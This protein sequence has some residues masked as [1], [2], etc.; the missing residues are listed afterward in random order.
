[1]PH[2]GPS[3]SPVL[4]PA[5][6]TR[7]QQD[8]NLVTRRRRLPLEI[9]CARGQQSPVRRALLPPTLAGQGPLPILCT[10]ESSLCR[11]Q[12]TW[13][14]EDYRA[15]TRGRSPYACI[16]LPLRQE[17]AASRPHTTTQQCRCDDAGG[18][19]I[20]ASQK[21]CGRSLPACLLPSTHTCADIQNSRVRARLP[22]PWPV[23]ARCCPQSGSKK[24]PFL[25]FLQ[26]WRQ[27]EPC[28]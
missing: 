26:R 12:L 19:R 11:A 1:M 9:P 14:R 20:Q 24:D 6:A 23:F 3:S 13:Q 18:G 21:H 8:T 7:C 27:V 17:A 10:H 28:S 16:H 2:R 25:S 22:R 15:M 4:T 5:C